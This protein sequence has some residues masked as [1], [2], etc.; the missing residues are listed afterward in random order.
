MAQWP[1][2]VTHALTTQCIDIG[3]RRHQGLERLGH[4]QQLIHTSAA[5]VPCHA[6]LQAAD[7]SKPPVLA[8]QIPRLDGLGQKPLL[9]ARLIRHAAMG[10]Q[11]AQQALRQHPQQR[12]IDEITR[13]AQ[14][15][16][17]GNGA[18]RIVR[19]QRGKHQVSGQR[20]LN[21]HIGCFQITNLPHHD[22]VGILPHQRAHAFG[23]TEIEL[24]LH[25]RLVE[26]R[27]DHFDRILDRG[28]IH[29][30][31]RHPL[32]CGIQRRG[33]AG[34]G[35]TGNQHNAMRAFHELLPSLLVMR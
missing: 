16:Q 25:L 20:R 15:D 35:R 21:R 14:F 23:K 22:D 10:A 2:A 9:L 24:R 31:G 33:L 7:S 17:A 8:S 34:A 30:F 13:N 29:L 4:G 6:A 5:V 26:R 32:E 11:G 18:G 19:M 1:H 27:L 28:H 3:L 12:G